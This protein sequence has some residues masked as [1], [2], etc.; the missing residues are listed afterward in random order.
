MDAAWLSR[1][2]S[3]DWLT[4]ALVVITA[5]YAWATF[6][7]LRVN[8]AMVVAMR[9]QQHA[10]MRPYVLVSSHF[11]SGTPFIYLSIKNVGKTAALDL[12]L[13]IDKDFYQLSEKR[14]DRNIAKTPAFSSPISSLPPGGELLYLLGHGPSLFGPPNAE[15]LAPL[16]FVV[17]ARYRI[18]GGWVSEKSIIDLRPYLNTDYFNDPISAE[19]K[20]VREVLGELKQIRRSI[21]EIGN[22]EERGL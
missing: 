15:Q 22:R 7:I 3:T 9:D 5:F 12:E 2:N 21:D 10:A 11:R 13:S 18:E 17:G 20:K 6:K 1:L 14:D 8:Q 19:I 4:L 16:E